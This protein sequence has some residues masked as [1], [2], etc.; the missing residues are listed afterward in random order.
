MRLSRL[1]DDDRHLGPITYAR[2]SPGWRPLRVVYSS[3]AHED[4]H[5]PNTLTAYACGWVARI[6][7]PKLL[8][9]YTVRHVAASWDAA[10][11]ERLGRNWYEERHP[12]EYGFSL[13]DGFLQV[14]YGR[15]GG[16]CADSS[17][18]QQWSCFLPW[19]QW[20]H[21]RRSL[22]G[23]QGELFETVPERAEYKTWKALEEAAGTPQE[24]E[25]LK[26]ALVVGAQRWI[27]AP[28]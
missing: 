4:G 22:Y 7:L 5:G 25:Q 6:S 17:L 26:A 21:V 10:T 15:R 3:G 24:L 16:A 18:W 11:V 8:G 27:S 1:T 28:T 20:R 12:R 23:L 13:S 2:C 19:T 9:D 14:F